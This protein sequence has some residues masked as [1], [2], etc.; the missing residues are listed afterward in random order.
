MISP[1][2]TQENPIPITY[3]HGNGTKLPIDIRATSSKKWTPSANK[4]A[5]PI[6]VF[7]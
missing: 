6:N 3:D 1:S 2:I 7:T 4:V 5:V